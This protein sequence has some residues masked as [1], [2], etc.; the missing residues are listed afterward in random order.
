MD[1]NMKI[2]FG[3][4]SKLVIEAWER[5]YLMLVGGF[6]RDI[7]RKPAM[8]QRIYCINCYMTNSEEN[9]SSWVKLGFYDVPGHDN[10]GGVQRVT[11]PYPEQQRG[12]AVATWY[13][14]QPPKWINIYQNDIDLYTCRHTCIILYPWSLTFNHIVL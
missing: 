11:T 14:H 13:V 10:P 7:W 3:D 5:E 4:G 12:C 6:Q 1:W 8:M 9:T 2:L